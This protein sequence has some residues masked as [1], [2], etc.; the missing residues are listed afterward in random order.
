MEHHL[1]AIRKNLNSLAEIGTLRNLCSVSYSGDIHSLSFN[2]RVEF[3]LKLKEKPNV[4][5]LVGLH[6]A[7]F[8]LFMSRR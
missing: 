7:G 1:S 4:R 3:S 6:Y 2:Y 5:K 8:V